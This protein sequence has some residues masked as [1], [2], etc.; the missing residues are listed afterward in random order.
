MSIVKATGILRFTYENDPWELVRSI[1]D[2]WPGGLDNT[3]LFSL[4]RVDSTGEWLLSFANTYDDR[5]GN[6]GSR[7]SKDP[8]VIWLNGLGA[9]WNIEHGVIHM[10][11]IGYYAVLMWGKM[12]GEFGIVSTGKI[13]TARVMD[14]LE[15]LNEGAEKGDLHMIAEALKSVFG[16]DVRIE[17]IDILSD[18]MSGVDEPDDGLARPG[19]V[20][21]SGTLG[22]GVVMSRDA[23]RAKVQFH[24][25]PGDPIVVAASSL[26]V[27]QKAR[28]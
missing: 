1:S 11:A 23:D 20:V 5:I 8:L 6:D 15:R 18:V 19:D 2:L 13:S 3:D 14:P 28:G 25:Y 17:S 22:M 27:T 4:V 24:D 16:P 10:T 21:T 7:E 12:S 26:T 9:Y